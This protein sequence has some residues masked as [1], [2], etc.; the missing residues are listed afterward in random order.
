[1]I[2]ETTTRRGFLKGLAA[3]VTLLTVAPPLI[4]EEVAAAPEAMDTLYPVREAGEFWLKVNGKWRL[5]GGLRSLATRQDTFEVISVCSPYRGLQPAGYPD[6]DAEIIVDPAAAQ[7]L[8]EI[9]LAD[10]RVDIGIGM[11]DYD[12]ELPQAS[13][14]NFEVEASPQF[15][16]T[17]ISG[18]YDKA[19]LRHRWP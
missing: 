4:M 6:F 18:T 12:Y 13:I 7:L 15:I 5:V 10:E 1:M 3:V 16:S 2:D 8:R 14:Y 11:R 19:V 9:T 17:T